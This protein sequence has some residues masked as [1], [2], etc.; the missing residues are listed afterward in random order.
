MFLKHDFIHNWTHAA[1]SFNSLWTSE[2]I[3]HQ[4]YQSPTIRLVVF[5]GAK[6]LLEKHIVIW[7]LVTNFGEIWVIK[8]TYISRN[9]F[10][11]IVCKISTVSLGLGVLQY[12]SVMLFREINRMSFWHCEFAFTR[13]TLDQFSRNKNC[14][15]GDIN[16]WIIDAC[17][18][19]HAYNLITIA[20]AQ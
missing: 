10:E 3:W 15:F 18:C 7:K 1:H 16:I 11:N 13:R 4:W 12:V 5:I 19:S 9:A 20:L 8:Q 14:T 2:A 6:L 17:H